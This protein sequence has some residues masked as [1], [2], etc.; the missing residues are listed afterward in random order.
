MSAVKI[1]QRTQI[2]LFC[3]YERHRNNCVYSYRPLSC[4]WF[5]MHS[6]TLACVSI[7]SQL[8][9]RAQIKR[10]GAENPWEPRKLFADSI[11]VSS[12]SADCI[13]KKGVKQLEA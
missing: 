6:N 10:A 5:L 12:F 4:E 2:T 8:I 13:I 1:E 11:S 3:H 9:H 7:D